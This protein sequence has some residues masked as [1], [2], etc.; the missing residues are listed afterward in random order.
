MIDMKYPRE[1]SKEFNVGSIDTLGHRIY[2]N[3]VLV[4]YQGVLSDNQYAEH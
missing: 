1:K 3:M 4:G 2:N